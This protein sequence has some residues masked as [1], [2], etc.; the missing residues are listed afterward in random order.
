MELAMGIISDFQFGSHVPPDQLSRIDEVLDQWA[1][2][3]YEVTKWEE[4]FLR[5]LADKLSEIRHQ[6]VC[7]LIETVGSARED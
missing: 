5:S 4:K 7:P 2:G 1:T 3:R 6:D